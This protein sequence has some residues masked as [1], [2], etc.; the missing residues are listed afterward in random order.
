MSRRQRVLVVE[1]DE[2]I[3]DVLVDALEMEGAEVRDAADGREALS[4]LDAWTPDA[5]LLDLMM[6]IMDGWT[7]RAHQRAHPTAATVP[8]IVLSASRDFGGRAD[9]LAPAVLIRKP[10]DLVDVLAKVD[11]VTA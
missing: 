3:R 6:P 8:V 11:A 5:I 1:D 4:I 9:D 10:L 7:F 2:A